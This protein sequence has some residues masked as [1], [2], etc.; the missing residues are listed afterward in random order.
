[1]YVFDVCMCV[2]VVYVHVC[3]H[4]GAIVWGYAWVGE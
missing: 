4:T 3:R 1:M 2:C